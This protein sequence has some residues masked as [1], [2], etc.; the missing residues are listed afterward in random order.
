MGIKAPFSG[1][2]RA[3]FRDEADFGWPDPESEVHH[4]G[5]GGHFEVEFVAVALGDLENVTILNVPAIFAEVNRDRMGS[6][7]ETN[8][9]GGEGVRLRNGGGRRSAIAG[10][11]QG[12]DVVDIHA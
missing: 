11:P 12:G 10:L 8:V 7:L 4:G 3:V 6:G 1:D 9:G 2:F 5:G